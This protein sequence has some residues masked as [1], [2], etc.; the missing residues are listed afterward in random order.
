M[1]GSW[2]NIILECNHYL[3]E[4]SQET[5]N[6]SV[7]L[8][9]LKIYLWI[10][11]TYK[12]SGDIPVLNIT[13]NDRIYCWIGK[14][15]FSN[16]HYLIQNFQPLRSTQIWF[17]W[18]IILQ[19]QAHKTRGAM[20]FFCKTEQKSSEWLPINQ[21]WGGS[22]R[23]VLKNRSHSGAPKHT[24]SYA[25]KVPSDSPSNYKQWYRWCVVPQP[26]S[27]NPH[28]KYLVKLLTSVSN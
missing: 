3:T 26:H 27:A 4:S 22:R 20:V 7:L 6:S 2:K 17:I 13:H 12:N 18:K 5:D 25:H 21:T 15:F 10:L 16:F 9:Y 24:R 8:N 11:T 1:L 28:R 23:Q 14:G 19:N